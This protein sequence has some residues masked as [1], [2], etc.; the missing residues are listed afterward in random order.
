M[1]P[2]EMSGEGPG[3]I[4][5]PHLALFRLELRYTVASRTTN[6][7]HQFIIYTEVSVSFPIWVSPGE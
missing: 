1:A 6:T 2:A 4:L 5:S 3:T 7:N